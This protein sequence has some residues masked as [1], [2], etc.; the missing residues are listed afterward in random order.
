MI[1]KPGGLSFR[2]ISTIN[3]KNLKIREEQLNNWVGGLLKKY[4]AAWHVQWEIQASIVKFPGAWTMYQ[5]DV[6]FR[7]EDTEAR[8]EAYAAMQ[9]IRY[10]GDIRDMFTKIQ[11][12]NDNAQLTVAALKKL[13]LDRLRLKILEQ[14]HTLDVT[15]KSDQE[16]M[17]IISKARRTAEKW[18]AAKKNLSTRAPRIES[19]RSSKKDKCRVQKI[20]TREGFQQQ[21]N[22]FKPRRFVNRVANTAVK[23]FATQTEGIPQH[24]LNRRKKA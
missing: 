1:S 17:E 10:D 12:H 4:A 18:E 19:T 6:V 2:P 8:D 24:E 21:Q 9:K 13:I 5:N 20:T 3:R 7:F 23:T 22:E 16:M 11:M 14:M 15:G